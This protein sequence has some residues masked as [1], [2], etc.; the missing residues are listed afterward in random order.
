MSS[1]VLT[2]TAAV[3]ADPP[4]SPHRLK[5]PLEPRVR[6]LLKW[7]FL[8]A[9]SSWAADKRQLIDEIRRHNATASQRFLGRFDVEALRDYLDHLTAARAPQTA[10][11]AARRRA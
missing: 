9:E 5:L 4:P 7:P 2:R 3:V 6:S 1:L 10:T 8:R 11:P